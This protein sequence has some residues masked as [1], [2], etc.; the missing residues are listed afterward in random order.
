MDSKLFLLE[1]TKYAVLFDLLFLVMA[2]FWLCVFMGVLVALSVVV[3]IVD[4]MLRR[5]HDVAFGIFLVAVGI[6]AT[7]LW[8]GYYFWPNA[9]IGLFLLTA[10]G[11]VGVLAYRIRSWVIAGGLPAG[12][13]YAS[14]FQMSP[15]EKKRQEDKIPLEKVV[16]F[17]VGPFLWLLAVQ[18]GILGPLWVAHALWALFRFTKPARRAARCSAR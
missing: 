1:I 16:K 9:A 8:A 5:P 3:H 7:G 10:G 13:R 4:F 2:I 11:A 18:V 6:T 14:I 15:E 12:R 17:I